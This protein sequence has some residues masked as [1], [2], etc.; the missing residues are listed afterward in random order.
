MPESTSEP[1]TVQVYLGPRSYEIAIVT[2]QL[3]ELAGHVEPWLERVSGSD[4]STGKALIVTDRNVTEPHSSTV[5]QSLSDAGW[6]CELFEIEPG[7][8]SKSL[9]VVSTIYDRLVELQADRQTLVVAVGGGVVGDVAGFAAATY[10]RGIPFIQVPTTLLADVDSSV[11]GKVGVNHPQGKNLIGAFYQPLGVFIDTATLKTLPD[12]DYRGGLAEVVKYGVIRDAEFFA[13]LE[14]HTGEI[15]ERTPRTLQYIIFRCCRLKGDVV[16]QDEFEQ[17]GLRSVLNY[18]HTFAHAFETL[19]G[20]NELL[21]GEAVSIGMVCASRLAERRGLIDGSLT[22]RQTAL[23]QKLGLPVRLPASTAFST[24]ALLD[25]MRLD[26]KAARGRL[27]FVLP[28]ELGNVELFDDVPEE[29]VRA[30]LDEAVQ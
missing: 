23:L 25:V 19:S 21:H 9:P 17:T 18:G 16:E 13:Y 10:A 3:S 15:H 7:E 8:R 4:G 12:R 11:G 6:I 30:V 14:N 1:L 29:D 5:R 2:D 20:Y 28:T 22:E 26:K 27:R 24:D